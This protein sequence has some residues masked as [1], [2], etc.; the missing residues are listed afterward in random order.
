MVRGV[1]PGGGW[2]KGVSED[3]QGRNERRKGR[4]QKIEAVEKKDQKQRD[5]RLDRQIVRQKRQL[6]RTGTDRIKEKKE[7]MS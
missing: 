6:K 4:C 5:R 2:R 7:G 1:R 3:G